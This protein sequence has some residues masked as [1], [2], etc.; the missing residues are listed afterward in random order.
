M[1]TIQIQ[2]HEADHNKILRAAGVKK[3][4]HGWYTVHFNG[5][6]LDSSNVVSGRRNRLGKIKV[7]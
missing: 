3:I 4:H 5:V 7:A 1:K 2:G 6:N